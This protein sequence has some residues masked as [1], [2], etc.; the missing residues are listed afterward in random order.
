MTSVLGRSADSGQIGSLGHYL[1]TDGSRGAPVAIDLEGP[2][3]G[4]VVG[5]RGSGKSYTLGVLAEEIGTTAGVSGIVVDPMGAFSGLA[6]APFARTVTQ[7]TIRADAVPPAGWCQLL[8]LDPAAGPGALLWRA[9]AT[10]DT[11]REMRAVVD[12]AGVP[13]ETRRAVLNHLELAASWETFDPSGLTAADLQTQGV[14]VLETSGTPTAAQAAIVFAVA[15]G[16]YDRALRTDD[17]PLPWLLVDEA[18]AV[19]DTVAGRAIRTLLTRGRHPGVSLVL[20]TQRPAAL[21]AV[22]ISQADLVVSHRLTA[23]PD[24]DALSRTNPTYLDGDLATQLPQG[25]GEALVV[26][27]ATESAVTITIRERRT[28]HEG[29]TPQ[30]SKRRTD[31]SPRPDDHVTPDEVVAPGTRS[32]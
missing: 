4:L 27:D 25:V 21:P 14:T 8:D 26:D 28:P 2:H 15:R 7:P 9:A 3:V 16:V 6:A 10:A 5:K 22:A 29:E 12:T 24:I 23:G 31:R 18:H 13:A 20:A 19:T 30:A 32:P 1:A 17:E 11:L